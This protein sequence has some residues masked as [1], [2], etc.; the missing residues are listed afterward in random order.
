LFSILVMASIGNLP[1]GVFPVF[2]RSSFVAGMPDLYIESMIMAMNSTVSH[3]ET[4][5]TAVAQCADNSIGPGYFLAG[6]SDQGYWYQVALAWNWPASLDPNGGVVNG[7]YSIYSVYGPGGVALTINGHTSTLNMLSG[8]ND[9]D[10]VQLGLSISN[11]NVLMRV[12][13]WR[14]GTIDQFSTSANSASQFVSIPQGGF[15]SNGYYTGV[16]TVEFHGSPFYGDEQRVVHKYPNIPQSFAWMR[17]EEFTTPGNTVVFD[18]KTPVN[19]NTPSQLQNL[20]FQG[21]TEA[22][23]S[24]TFITGTQSTGPKCLVGP[25]SPTAV[26]I[27]IA[28]LAGIAIMAGVIGLA[29]FKRQKSRISRLG[30]PKFEGVSR[31]S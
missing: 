9:G 12:H 17:I 26:V 21:A 29:Y 20:T 25:V 30:T 3:V 4:N 31:N 11:N 22:S 24:T 16:A 28:S 27:A 10:L 13:D 23:N 15:D 19:Y 6:R 1:S 7:F 8:V 14:S 5:V 2:K 18:K